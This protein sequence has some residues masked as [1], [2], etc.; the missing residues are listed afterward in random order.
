M[1][2]V[3]AAIGLLLGLPI[4]LAL[5]LARVQPSRLLS[6]PA[7][8]YVEVVR[9]TPLLVQILFI[10]FVLPGLRRQPAGVHERHHRAH[11]EFR[12]LP[13]RDLPRRHRVDRAGQMEA[14]RS[15]G[16]TYAQAMRRV[17]LPQTFRRV[18]RRSPTRGLRC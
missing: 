12:R 16:M 18:C 7:A 8:V 5:A 11:A 2:A 1:T 6:V 14:A 15:L 10:Y 17:I 13:R 9:G 4:G 3:L